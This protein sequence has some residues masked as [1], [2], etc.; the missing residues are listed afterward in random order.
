MPAQYRRAIPLIPALAAL[1]AARRDEIVITTMGAAREWPKF[2]PHPLD[3]HYIPSAMGQ[4]PALGLGLALAKP[5][6]PV[7]ILNGDGCMLMNLGSLV[8]IAASGAKNLVLF[9]LNNSI[10]EV[11]GG[12]RTAGGAIDVD[13]VALARAAGF[14]TALCFDDLK[15]WQ[16]HAATTSQLAGPALIEFRV[17]PVAGDYLLDSPGPIQER[18][19]RFQQA[20]SA[21]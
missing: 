11:T 4:A 12:Q 6:R 7:W 3:F 15:T 20:L 14:P 1:H 13:F 9:V 17:E 19:A 16:T 10:Y 18:L 2:K 5:Q 21:A 8:T